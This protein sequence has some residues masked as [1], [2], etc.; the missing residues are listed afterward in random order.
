MA[1]NAFG[2][3]LTFNKVVAGHPS[4]MFD[5]DTHNIWWWDSIG[6]PAAFGTSKAIACIY[7]VAPH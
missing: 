7:T 6:T 4:S 3:L 1:V 2:G 5:F